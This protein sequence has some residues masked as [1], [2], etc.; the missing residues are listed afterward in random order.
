MTDIEATIARVLELDEKATP[1][2]WKWEP[3]WYAAEAPD[4]EETF[5]NNKVEDAEFIAHARTA[6]PELALECRRLGKSLECAELLN[7]SHVDRM[8][9]VYALRQR[10]I[11]A[12]CLRDDVGD[13]DLVD[14]VRRLAS[15]SG[16]ASSDGFESEFKRRGWR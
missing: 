14:A 12:A 9:S 8:K 3:G 13:D 6:A 16:E 5:C 1:G 11:D 4:G 10:I 7:E 15:P 2:P